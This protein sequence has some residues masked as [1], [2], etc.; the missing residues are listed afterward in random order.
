M[1]AVLSEHV[2]ASLKQSVPLKVGDFL[3]LAWGKDPIEPTEDITIAQ[4]Q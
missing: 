1:L 3:P 4:L 2:P